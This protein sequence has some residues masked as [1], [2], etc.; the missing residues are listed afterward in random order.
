ME[1]LI[2]KLI[3]VTRET[4]TSRIVK[5]WN[6]GAL[7]HKLGHR[8]AGIELTDE[9]TRIDFIYRSPDHIDMAQ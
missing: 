7:D 1:V 2:E 4:G 5:L 8:M 3:E 6:P 9:Y